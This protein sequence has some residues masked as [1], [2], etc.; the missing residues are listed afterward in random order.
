M[1]NQG[2]QYSDRQLLVTKE[3]S[4]CSFT[5]KAGS[6][7]FIFGGEPFA[8]T[9]YMYWNFVSSSQERIEKAKADWVAHRF[10]K[11]PSDDGY[12]PLPGQK[13]SNS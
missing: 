1:E 7:L 10:P 2:H 9:R 4:L 12:V 5:A 3:A 6:H 13:S 11:V 8:E